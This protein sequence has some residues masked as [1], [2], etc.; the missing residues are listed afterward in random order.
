M[1]PTLHYFS[2][3][4][5]WVDFVPTDGYVY[6]HWA[7]TPM[8]SAEFRA[9]YVHAH[10]LPRR[11]EV[12]GIPADHRAMPTAPALA[13]R[14]WLLPEWQPAVMADTDFARYAVLPTLTP[15][16]HL[17]PPDM[18]KQLHRVPITR[19]FGALNSATGWLRETCAA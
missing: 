11:F 15:E 9:P 13:D 5:S 7:G 1:E 4:E 16:H 2:N 6:L 18:A 14:E 17:H 12:N 8:S 10:N 3:A 19:F